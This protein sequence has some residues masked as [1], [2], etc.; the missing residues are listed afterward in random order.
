MQLTGHSTEQDLTSEIDSLCD[1]DA[2]SYTLK[3]K[4]RRINAAYEDIV[5]KLI[6]ASAG[7]KWHF[8]DSNYS[9]NPTGL[10]TLVN[11]QEAYQLIGDLIGA[12]W[13]GI[14]TTTPLLNFLGVSVKDN[15]GIWHV[16]KPIRLWQDLLSQDL[17][18]AEH[19]KTDGRPE[20]Y[21]LREDFLILYPAPDNGVSVT[22][23]SGLKVFF[24]RSAELFTT[25]DTTKQPGFI[26]PYHIILAYKAALPYCAQYNKDRVP[27]ILSEIKRIEDELL[28][29]YSHRA[30]DE[31]NVLTGKSRN[32]R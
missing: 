21:E 9:A 7:G 23:S 32:F 22:L 11:S 29:F 19:F 16:L 15:S 25:S 14:N 12:S 10:F 5:A 3:S 24:Q 30:L 8:G 2:N 18:P 1:S 20:Y 6:V 17:D 26:S 27:F 13:T 31:P 28:A 4:V